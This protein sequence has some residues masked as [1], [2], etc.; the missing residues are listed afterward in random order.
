VRLHH[1][2]LLG[3]TILA[4]LGQIFFKLGATGKTD[5]RQML[6]LYVASGMLCYALGTLGWIFALSKLPLRVVYPYTALTFVLVYVG[7]VGFL[8][9][10]LDLRSGIGVGCVLFGLFLLTVGTGT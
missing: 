10:K 7:A 4:A 9:E 5:W 8:G 2:V 1:A 3:A 6:N